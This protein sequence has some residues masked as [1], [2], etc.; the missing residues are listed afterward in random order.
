MLF[1]SF[2]PGGFGAARDVG[3]V[4]ARVETAAEL[5]ESLNDWA[6]RPMNRT[7][8]PSNPVLPGA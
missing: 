1:R 5:E 4:Y 8:M 7:V 6:Q 2:S 3:N